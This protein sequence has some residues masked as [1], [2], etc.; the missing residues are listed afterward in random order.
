MPAEQR[1]RLLQSL[2]KFDLELTPEKQQA[3]RD[4]DRQITQLVPQ[5]RAQYFW[6]LR[7]YHNWL[8]SLPENRREEIL[9]QPADDRLATIRKLAAQHPV[10]SSETPEFL[11]IAE[12][13][14]MSPFELASAYRIWKE[15]NA[16][17]HERIERIAQ[18]KGRR[19]SLFQLGNSL[20][21][22]LP[23]ET[24]P[25]DFDEEYWIREVEDYWRKV[26]PVM[27]LEEGARNK[28]G[29]D[30]AK[31]AARKKQDAIRQAIHRRQAVNL[32]TARTKVKS[33]EP[34]K[35]TEFV[36]GLPPWL[37]HVVDQYPPDEA[38]HRL[39]W[40]YRMVFPY[41]DEIGASHHPS[42]SAAKKA[43]RPTPKKPGT[44]PAKRKPAP[45]SPS[46]APF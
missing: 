32:Y 24:K 4:L 40:A 30:P 27:L 18:G 22:A 21:P 36:T 41:P 28:G 38:R 43:P 44:T 45:T 19:K 13:G 15:S 34:D 17:Q 9:A 7:R 35:L 8:D 29:E 6:V 37:Q 42:A 46:D 25:A 39:T 10:P 26:R 31:E 16:T 20:K 1:S 2:Q 14:E 23:Q 11:R 3:V 12:V 5:Q 33:V